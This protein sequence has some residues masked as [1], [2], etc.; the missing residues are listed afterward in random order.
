VKHLFAVIVSVPDPK[1]PRA[2]ENLA[3]QFPSHVQI[4]NTPETSKPLEELDLPTPSVGLLMGAR[5]PV[6][7]AG[8]IL[9]VN[10]DGRELFGRGRKPSKWGVEFEEFATIE[11]A[12]ERAAS[13]KLGA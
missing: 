10:L 4:G 5:F 13:V 7:V 8:E 2:W 12:L 6:F 11:E 3:M 9:V 1:G